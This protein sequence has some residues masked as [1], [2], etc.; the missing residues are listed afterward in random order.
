MDLNLTGRKALVTG[1]SRGLGRAIAE[2]LAREGA[3]LA[4]CARGAESL[5]A[6]AKELRELGHT[7]YAQ[8]VDVSDET[9]VTG[10]VE[11]AA[12]E[13]SGL[14]IVISN[15]SA[16]AVK[17]PGQWEVSFRAD[18]LAFVRLVEAAVPYLEQSD[19][20]A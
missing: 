11:A 12:R 6:V 3:D 7:V 4:L 5:E 10:F 16:G 13:L 2:E 9:A 14:D 15:V 19:A 18:L 1:A 8:A 17:G 20:A